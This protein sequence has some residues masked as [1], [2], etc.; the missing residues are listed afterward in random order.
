M[1][2]ILQNF[3]Q[4]WVLYEQIYVSELM[5]IESQARNYILTAI[6]HDKELEILEGNCKRNIKIS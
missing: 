5:E 4:Q 3:D 2:K 6:E 1:K